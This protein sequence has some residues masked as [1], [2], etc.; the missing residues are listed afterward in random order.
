MHESMH[1][2][3]SSDNGKIGKQSPKPKTG[4]KLMRKMISP[5]NKMGKDQDRLKVR[6][7][8]QEANN[9]KKD[10]QTDV[11]CT[12]VVVA[13]QSRSKEG[14]LGQSKECSKRIEHM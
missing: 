7:N 11:A 6:P 9:P 8:N 4:L 3:H 10:E 12:S 5:T 13:V 1:V 2:E 14:S